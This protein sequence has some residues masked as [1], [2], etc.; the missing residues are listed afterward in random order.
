MGLT[1]A[2]IGVVQFLGPLAG[3]IGSRNMNY[4]LTVIYTAYCNMK[5]IFHIIFGI[6]MFFLWYVLFV[7]VQF[8]ICKIANTFVLALGRVS[9]SRRKELRNMDMKDAVRLVYW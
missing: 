7:M 6:Y 5:L 1:Y 9:P 2:L 8:W 3:A 4:P